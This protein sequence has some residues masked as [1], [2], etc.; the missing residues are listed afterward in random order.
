MDWNGKSETRT[1]RINDKAEGFW[2]KYIGQSCEATLYGPDGPNPQLNTEQ[3]NPPLPKYQSLPLMWLDLMAAEIKTLKME[4][5]AKPC[6]CACPCVDLTTGV[7][8]CVNEVY[9][10]C[11]CHDKKTE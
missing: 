5:N 3:L 2:R 7:C 10:H 8:D 11:C 4:V 6:N 1:V 9:T